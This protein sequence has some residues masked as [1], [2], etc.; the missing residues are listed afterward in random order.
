LLVVG[1]TSIGS[2]TIHVRVLRLCIPL[3][4]S[5]VALSISS[6]VTTSSTSSST[7]TPLGGFLRLKMF[8]CYILPTLH[9][10]Y[11]QLE[12]G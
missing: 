10:V 7:C 11:I 6:I 5:L 4:I 1:I 3:S 8:T 9:L 2:I 12:T